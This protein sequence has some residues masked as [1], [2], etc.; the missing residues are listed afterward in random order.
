MAA[1]AVVVQGLCSSFISRDGGYAMAATTPG[2]PADSASNVGGDGERSRARR[3]DGGW[4]MAD[5]GVR[6]LVMAMAMG[7]GR[8][9]WDGAGGGAWRGQVPPAL[10]QSSRGL[11]S[12]LANHPA[13]PEMHSRATKL[14]APK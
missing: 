9:C 14:R 1:A 7:E 12:S 2:Q 4:R 8:R 5:G 11:A 3:A 6:A 10:P 13:T